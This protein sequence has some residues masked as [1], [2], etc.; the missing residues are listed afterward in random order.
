MQGLLNI[1]YLLFWLYVTQIDMNDL[2][3]FFSVL[4]LPNTLPWG[5]CK[6]KTEEVV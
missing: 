6:P 5:P 1:Q 4:L 3:V 2:L